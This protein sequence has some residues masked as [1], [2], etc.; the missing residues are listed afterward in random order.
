MSQI[1]FLATLFIILKGNYSSCSCG[2][3][4][5]AMWSSPDVHMWCQLIEK[6]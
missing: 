5:I 3:V 2:L 1:I 4:L 6:Y